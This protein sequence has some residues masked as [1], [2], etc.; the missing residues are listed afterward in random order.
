MERFPKRVVRC[1]PRAA[2]ACL[3]TSFILIMLSGCGDKGLVSVREIVR[4]G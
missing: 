1:L 2:S 4:M 3:A